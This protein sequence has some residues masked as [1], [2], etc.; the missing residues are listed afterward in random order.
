MEGASGQW[1]GL[2]S[3]ALARLPGRGC[4]GG[5]GEGTV[6]EQGKGKKGKW[7]E[8]GEDGLKQSGRGP[9]RGKGQKINK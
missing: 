7:G 8:E 4:E 3:L 1:R 9:G 6:R 2:R 5:G